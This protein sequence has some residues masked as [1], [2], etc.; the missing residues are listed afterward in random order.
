MK[1]KSLLLLL[2]LGPWALLT[3]QA[4]SHSASAPFSD[5]DEPG[6]F[7]ARLMNAEVHIRGGDVDEVTV[8]TE[9]PR[10][11]GEKPREDGMRVLSSGASFS[12]SE[13]DNV[14][15]LDYSPSGG[16]ADHAEFLITVPHDTH[17]DIEVNI[18][19]EILITDLTGD[20]F[21]KNLNGEISLQNHRG[22]AII[23]SMNGEIMA[24]LAELDPE[25]PLS[26][27]SMNGEIALHLP[28]DAEANVRFR[29]QNGTILTNFSDEVLVTTTTSGRTFAPEAH[30]EIA[31][32]AAEMAEEA[33]EVAMEIAEEVREAVMEAREE[34]EMELQ[35]AREE[36]AEA[37]RDI[38]EAKAEMKQAEREMREAQRVAELELREARR[39][40]AQAA[41]RAPRAPRPPSI[42][43]MAGGKVVSGTL[44]GGGVDLQVASMNGDIMIKKI[45]ATELFEDADEEGSD[46]GLFGDSE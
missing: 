19:G 1:L 34:M 20:V 24:E 8:H 31:E 15:V 25:H 14:M 41:P 36:M 3:A 46:E 37:E 35:E 12:L 21:V 26:F 7:L 10:N 17:L 44:N 40:A 30:E 28:E 43:S 9:A 32:F 6:R 2:A 29:T 16:W 13:E 11:A 27:T 33:I 38:R 23:E 45:P 18:G 39:V 5:P 42:P 4:K 22:G